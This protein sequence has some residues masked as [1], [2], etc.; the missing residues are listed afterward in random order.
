MK[1]FVDVAKSLT[2]DSGKPDPL[3]VLAD[4]NA[5]LKQQVAKLEEKLAKFDSIAKE[6]SANEIFESAKKKIVRWY[7][8]GGVIVFLLTAF[9]LKIF[10]DYTEDLAKKKL[11]DIT[12]SDIR[13]VLSK[14]ADEKLN[15]VFVHFQDSAN[16]FWRQR[17]NEYFLTASSNVGNKGAAES[18]TS[19]VASSTTDYSGD[20]NP[21]ENQGNESSGPAFA[22]CTAF[23]YAIFHKTGQKLLLSPRNLYNG[24]NDGYDIGVYID[25]A[26]QYLIDQGVVENKYWP[27]VPGQFGSSPPAAVRTAT[28][29]KIKAA[30]QIPFVD[31]TGIR[32]AL[33]NNK[34]VVGNFVVY[35][36]F[37]SY[38]SGVITPPPLK[39]I[40][41][42]S[43]AI[44]VVGFDD[45]RKIFKCRNSWGTAWGEGGYFY[46]AYSDVLLW[47]KQ[48]YVLNL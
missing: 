4:E 26:F 41:S 7:T 45:N 12:D 23:E 42:Q 15:I 38:A 13:K 40:A 5:D 43:I 24:I 29:Y 34:I 14:K 6:V 27:Y 16:L 9:G 10:L 31:Y 2:M 25:K 48:A 28:H 30:P 36:E 47:I 17:L 35:N 21:I 32:N 3:K 19:I 22:M 37:L 33:I 20:L 18:T 1:Q 8:V 46:I 39:E 44:C 11:E